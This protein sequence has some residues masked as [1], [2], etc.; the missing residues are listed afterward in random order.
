ML[1]VTM[2]TIFEEPL[3]TSL[4][5]GMV[6]SDRLM[7]DKVTKIIFRQTVECFECWMKHSEHK[8]VRSGYHGP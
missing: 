2:E 1:N 5:T 6:I 7:E 8:L 3:L 4:E